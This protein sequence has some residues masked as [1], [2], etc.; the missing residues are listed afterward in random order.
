MES[1][2][3][4]YTNN[5]LSFDDIMNKKQTNDTFNGKPSGLWFS[6]GNSWVKWCMEAEFSTCDLETCNIYEGE[7][8]LEKIYLVDSFEKL[9]ELHANYKLDSETINWVKLEKEYD[10]IMF[11]NYANIKK[12][13]FQNNLLGIFTWFSMI[14][15]DSVCI[16]NKNALKSFN[17]FFI[18]P[19]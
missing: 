5:L 8:N 16:W 17:N 4:H 9:K 3:L 13:I 11:T 12:Y 2:F 1:K 18:Y 7:L 19:N 6:I 14:D 10:G 15:I